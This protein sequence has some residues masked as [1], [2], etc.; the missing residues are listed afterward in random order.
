[1][2][3]CAACAIATAA[4]LGTQPEGFGAHM[5]PLCDLRQE[6]LGEGSVLGPLVEEI[7]GEGAVFQEIA[8]LISYPGSEQ[9][10]LHPDTPF[11]SPPSLYA[12]FVALQDVEEDM[13]PTVYLRGTHTKAAHSE[14]YGGDLVAARENSG[15][16]TAPVAEDF[17][18]SRPVSRALLKKGDLACYN[19][20]VRIACAF[21][22]FMCMCM[23][24]CYNDLATISR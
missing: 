22:C 7:M 9:Q 19:Q 12:C 15:L 21:T 13:G 24:M 23:C 8:C 14:F 3:E 16:R 11:S 18:R 2:I 10:P 4:A 5:W 1:M 6:L 20:Q 17:L